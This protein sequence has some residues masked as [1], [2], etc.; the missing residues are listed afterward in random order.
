L[1]H[2]SAKLKDI[3]CSSQNHIT[4]IPI[5]KCFKEIELDDHS[6]VITENFTT[7]SLIQIHICKTILLVS[8]YF[9]LEI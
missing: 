2:P 3:W 5:N 1:I 9:K 7:H 8:L 6:F 4:T